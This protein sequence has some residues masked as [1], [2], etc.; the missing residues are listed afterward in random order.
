MKLH[1][2]VIKRNEFLND[3]IWSGRQHHV[4]VTNY[5]IYDFGIYNKTAS[6]LTHLQVWVTVA[7]YHWPLQSEMNGALNYRFYHVFPSIIHNWNAIHFT[8]QQAVR[9]CYGNMPADAPTGW[10]FCYLYLPIYHIYQILMHLNSMK[11]CV[12]AFQTII[13]LFSTLPFSASVI[14]II[15]LR[16][17]PKKLFL[18][19]APQLFIFFLSI[20]FSNGVFSLFI[21]LPRSEVQTASLSTTLQ[22]KSLISSWARFT[23]AF[24]PSGSIQ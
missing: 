11:K 10:Q 9:R 4:F 15:L 19:H 22:V 6:Q 13:T 16:N 20:P 17:T 7:T 5:S 3:T 8:Q 18:P 21:Y 24:I 1:Y 23:Q 12:T 2:R 14:D